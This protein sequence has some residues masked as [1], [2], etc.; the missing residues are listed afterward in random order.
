MVRTAVSRARAANP[1]VTLVLNDF[2]LSSAYECLIEGLLEAGVTVD[3]IGL[4][5]HMQKGFRGEEYLSRALDRFARFGLPLHL[6]ESTLVSGHL[7]PA[8]IDDLNDY[9]IPAWPSTPGGEARQ[10]DDIVRLYRC[11]FEHPAVRSINYWGLTDDGS[12]LGAPTGLLRADGTRKPAYDALDGLIKGDWWLPP[13]RLRTDADGRVTVRGCS[14]EYTVTVDGRA[15]APFSL[16][17]LSIR[18]TLVRVEGGEDG[19][20]RTG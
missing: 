15:A 10:A 8:E 9:R 4:Q 7:M 2:D 1:A 18:P 17:E 5:T 6:T 11:L 13:T 12:W 16:T 19:H 20:G 14:G 3:A